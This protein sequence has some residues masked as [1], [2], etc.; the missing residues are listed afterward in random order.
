MLRCVSIDCRQDLPAEQ[1]RHVKPLQRYFMLWTGNSPRLDADTNGFGCAV[2]C[3][4]GRIALVHGCRQERLGH[5]S[6][7]WSGDSDYCGSHNGAL[8]HGLDTKIRSTSHE[9]DLEGDLG[10]ICKSRPRQHL[11]I[12]FST[13]FPNLSPESA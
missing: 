3:W 4:N 8:R 7:Q 12:A 5:G 13:A 9:G 6:G 2:L 10:G 11:E 1:M